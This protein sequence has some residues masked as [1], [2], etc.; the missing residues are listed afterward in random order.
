MTFPGMKDARQ[1]ADLLAYLKDATR[2]GHTP[3]AAQG[4]SQVGGMMMG[5]GGVPNLKKARSSGSRAIDQS[6]R[7][8]L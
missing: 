5:G 8:H 4:G 3:K 7:R 6:L 2:P 1:R